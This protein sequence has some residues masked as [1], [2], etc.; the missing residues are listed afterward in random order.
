MLKMYWNGKAWQIDFNPNLSFESI[1]YK[2]AFFWI[3]YQDEID[4]DFIMDYIHNS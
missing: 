3:K 4:I 1:N 2:K